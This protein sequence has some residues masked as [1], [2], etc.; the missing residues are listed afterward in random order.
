VCSSDLFPN[1]AP[2]LWHYS[3]YRAVGLKYNERWITFY[4]QGDMKDAWKTGHSGV[5]ELQA[6]QAYKLGINIMNYAF[7][8]YISA[9]F[10]Q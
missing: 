3:G 6:L 2:P 8:Q 7:N 1:G 10:G 4:H 5:T 9:H